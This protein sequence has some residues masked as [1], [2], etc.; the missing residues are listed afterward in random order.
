MKKDIIQQDL[1]NKLATALR[2]LCIEMVEEAKSGHP[3]MPMGFADVATILF[4]Y[5]LRFN[6]H[7]PTWANRDRFIL[8]PGHGSA[9]LYSLLFL[10]GYEKYKLSDLKK[11]RKLGSITPGHPEFDHELGIETTTGPLGQGLAN[12]VGMAISAKKLQSFLKGAIDHKIYVVVGDGCLMEG[13][14]HESMSFA[15]H[16]ELNNLVVL[17]DDNKISIDGPTSLATSDMT[18][19]RVSSYNWNVI[20]IDGHDPEAIWNALNSAQKSD[21]PMF[22]ACRT[23]IGYGSPS[24]EN[25]EESH[26]KCLGDKEITFIKKKFNW[27]YDKFVIPAP[28][29]KIWRDFYKRSLSDYLNWEKVH[30]KLYLENQAKNRDL[31]Q[32]LSEINKFK[33]ELVIFHNSEATR[34]SSSKVINIICSNTDACI[35][36]SADLSDSNGTRSANQQIFSKNNYLG[37]YIHYGVREHAMVAIMNGIH[38]HSEYIVYGGTFLVFSDYC[39][40]SIRLASLMKL[41]IILVFTHDS[42]GVGE[43]GPTHQPIEHI[44]ALRAIPNLNVY[45]PADAIETIEC[46]EIILKMLKQTKVPSALCLSR[47]N[48]PQLRNNININN[49]KNLVEL[50]AYIL[51][52]SREEHSISIFASGSELSIALNVAKILEKNGIGSKVISVPCQELFWKQTLEYQMAILCNNALKVAIEAGNDQSWY[53]IIG[54]HG[55][56][57]GMDD[58]GK[59]API[60]DLYKYFQLTVEKISSK[61]LKILNPAS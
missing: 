10:T 25:S 57:F 43:D 20:S 38:I 41:P 58:F 23:K 14:S 55:V 2:V 36:G 3:G 59:S 8:S 31:D 27:Q 52:Q 53:K 61:I 34:K 30:K 51:Y 12:A 1:H 16:L 18:L 56:F 39:R 50:G 13:I 32:A 29:L 15:G 42:I 6:P 40:P 24:F 7:D 22:I 19:A 48:L 35:G 44:S 4:Q 33:R 28:I 54:P 9:L 21:K 47:Q 17:F 5:F 45:R 26:G 49:T 11:F 37:N 46:W 60:D